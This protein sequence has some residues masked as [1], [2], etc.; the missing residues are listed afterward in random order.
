MKWLRATLVS[1]L[2]RQTLG[3]TLTVLEI[4]SHQI[5]DP[6]EQ[7]VCEHV[8]VFLR[9]LSRSPAIWEEVQSAWP[10][11]QARLEASPHPWK[12]VAGPISA[13]MQYCRDLGWGIDDPKFWQVQGQVISLDFNPFL[14]YDLQRRV[15]DSVKHSR[16]QSISLQPGGHGA[17]D[18]LD[19]T[20]HRRL[21]AKGGKK[22]RFHQAIWQ[23][24]VVHKHNGGHALCPR[25]QQPNTLEHVLWD[26]SRW[27]GQPQLSAK[28]R[29][30][31]ATYSHPCL[32]LRALVPSEY[33]RTPLLNPEE[34]VQGIW[35]SGHL[36]HD[37]VI[38]TDAS[39]GRFSSDPR[40]R[41][42]GWAVVLG[43]RSGTSVHIIATAS[44]VLP[45]PATVLDGEVFAIAKAL[46]LSEGV[47]DV[48]TDSR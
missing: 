47:L 19:W 16:L 21:V 1:N 43:R 10:M 38:G 2:G 46:E 9:I 27:A 7:T 36:D 8:Q 4:H 11:I 22:L 28:L 31:K 12:I 25:C 5:P 33:V 13:M 14:C 20:I 26:C 44:G 37:L 35:P 40:L 30:M 48:T 17:Q 42:V 23:A 39:G 32:W 34:V 41:A 15:R 6:L 29:A 24:A 18:G 3:G 45:R